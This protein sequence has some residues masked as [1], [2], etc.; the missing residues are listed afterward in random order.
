MRKIIL[1][2][3]LFSAFALAQNYQVVGEITSSTEGEA[4]AVLQYLQTN[5]GTKI[6]YA[7]VNGQTLTTSIG[8]VPTNFNDMVAIVTDLKQTFSTRFINWQ[9]IF[10]E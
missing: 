4:L 5:Y 9:I 10:E 8:I 1:L 7:N 3:L 2:T 6:N